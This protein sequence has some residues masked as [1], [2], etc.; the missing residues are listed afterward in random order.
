MMLLDIQSIVGSYIQYEVSL[1]TPDAPEAQA[2]YQVEQ[3][4]V[5]HVA[6]PA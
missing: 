2:P 5:S 3:E 1:N 4:M 6:E